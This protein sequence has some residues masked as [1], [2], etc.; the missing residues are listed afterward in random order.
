MFIISRIFSDGIDWGCLLI[1]IERRRHGQRISF[2][3]DRPTPLGRPKL[4]WKDVV[5]ADLCKKH[6]NISLP[7]E[8]S[9]WRNCTPTHYELN[10][11]MKQPLSKYAIF[12]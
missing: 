8:R 1:Y 2:N 4:S 12:Y 10:K 5:K 9:K 11:E 6:L 3:A 7:S